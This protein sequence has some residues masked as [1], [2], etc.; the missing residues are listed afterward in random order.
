MCDIIILSGFDTYCNLYCDNYNSL[1]AALVSTTLLDS[2]SVC[3][4]KKES[5]TYLILTCSPPSDN[6]KN[7]LQ[8]LHDL[9]FPHIMNKLDNTKLLL[10][11]IVSYFLNK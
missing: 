3:A 5:T 11:N 7:Q 2:L 6:H 9:Y 8:V 10:D 4:H 1:L